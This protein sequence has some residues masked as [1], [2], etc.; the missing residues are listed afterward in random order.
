MTQITGARNIIQ[1]EEVSYRA[2]VTEGTFTRLGATLN[3][4]SDFQYDSHAWHL[5]GPYRLFGNAL[6][7][8]GVFPVLFDFEIVGY[9][10][11]SGETG[12]SGTT[13]IDIRTLINGGTDDGSIFTTKPSVNS[14]SANSSYSLVDVVNS[15]V[16][17]LPT[18]HTQA[19][20]NKVNFNRGEALRLDINSA[21][22]GAS[23]FQFQ[24]LFRPR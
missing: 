1:Q 9:I 18:G 16:L 13:T 15:D 6:G 23:N 3:F 24:I 8:D 7:P 22:T 11:Y 4:I 10:M 14:S 20:F 5:N 12:T 17:A 19:I 2:G 21:M